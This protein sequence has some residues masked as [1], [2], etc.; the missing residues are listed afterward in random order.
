MLIE[1][2]NDRALHSEDMKNP[3]SSPRSD[4][5]FLDIIVGLHLNAIHSSKEI[6]YLNLGDTG[7]V[8][9]KNKAI[10]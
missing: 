3:N 8:T 1:F 9:L 4:G 7:V 5:A 6:A 2:D 10:C